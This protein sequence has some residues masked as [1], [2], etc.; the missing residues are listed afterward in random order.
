MGT[1]N[2]F[3]ALAEHIV[4]ARN[5]LSGSAAMVADMLRS[6]IIAMRGPKTTFIRLREGVTLM[7]FFFNVSA[8]L[9]QSVQEQRNGRGRTGD[10]P[11]E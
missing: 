11:D 10:S 5:R 4:S 8:E 9:K 3:F 6:C 2:A 7:P 1:A